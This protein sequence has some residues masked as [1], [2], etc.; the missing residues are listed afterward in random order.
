MFTSI[1]ELKKHPVFHYFAE[2]SKIPRSSGNEKAISDYLVSFAKERNLEVI[3]D[4]SLNVIIKK[5]ASKGYEDKP[6]VI[7]QGHMDM[8]CEKNEETVHDFRKDPIRLR[9][10]KDMLYATNTT[11]G[12]DNGIAVAYALALLDTNDLIHPALEIVMTT[13]EETTMK[14]AHSVDPSHF[15]GTLFINLDSEEDGT[16]LVSCAG[17][18]TGRL[19][20]PV[21]CEAT[22]AELHPYRMTI[23]GLKGG[24]SGMAIHKGRG[25]ANK[26]MGRILYDLSSSIPYTLHA[27]NGG[28]KTNAIPREASA[29][30]SLDDSHSGTLQNEVYKWNEMLKTELRVSDPDVEVKVKRLD[31]HVQTAF[32]DKTTEKIISA[33]MLTPSG[34]QTMSMD[35]EG[36]VESSTNL[37]VVTTQGHEVKLENEIRSSVKSLKTHIVNQLDV[38]AQ[39][40]GGK[41]TTDSDYPEWGYNADSTIRPL[42]EKTYKE[43]F[44]QEA[45]VMG[46]HAGLECGI[47]AEKIPDLDAISLGPDMFDV[48]TP[49]E[50]LS[51]P[52]T[53]RTWDYLLAVLK[54]M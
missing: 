54:S 47:F 37:G 51:I 32:S 17:G 22:S 12:A 16:F 28:L 34:V 6:P 5:P 26:L 35:I 13:E 52:S 9:I 50:H 53:I 18:V 7:L 44:G 1:E 4:E 21:V 31:N 33:L 42:F 41:F 8:V 30:I 20:I 43:M 39:S 14:G 24:H 38:T 19:S 25:N 2:I 15:K 48:H 10:V 45:K 40:L 29:V 49:N 3:Q 23:R 11:L 27:L 36:M 46:I